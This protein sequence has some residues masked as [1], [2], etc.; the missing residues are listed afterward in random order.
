M[1][2]AGEIRPGVS[3]VLNRLTYA[4]TLSHL[5]RINSPIGREGK[6]AKPRQL[7]NSQWGMICPAGERS[8][9]AG[10]GRGGKRS[11]RPLP[12]HA[13]PCWSP[14]H[15]P[16]S[17]AWR[18]RDARGAGVWAGQELGAHDLHLCGLRLKPC[19]RLPAGAAG[20][21]APGRVCPCVCA[22]RLACARSVPTAMCRP[23]VRCALQEWATEDLEEISPSVV[24]KATKIFVNGERRLWW[25]GVRSAALHCQLCK[26]AQGVACT[27]RPSAGVWVGIHR[28]PQLLVDTLRTMRR[29]V[30]VSTEVGVV[31][32]IRLQV[33][34]RADEGLGLRAGAPRLHARRC[35]EAMPG[36]RRPVLTHPALHTLCDPHPPPPPHATPHHTRSC[37]CTPT[38]GAAAARCSLWRTRRSR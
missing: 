30:D 3:Q 28:D 20:C 24:P 11:A 4:S 6:I 2:G 14:S 38:T 16:S 18:H 12:A 35:S 15:H 8:R 25:G 19:P 34:R 31:H 32:D 17:P 29:Q 9:G 5:R 1:V 7:H 21:R 37:A 22:L 13:P 23:A 33:R 27:R 26:A 36:P 10:R